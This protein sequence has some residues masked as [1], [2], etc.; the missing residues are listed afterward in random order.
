MRSALLF[1]YFAAKLALFFIVFSLILGSV[2]FLSRVFSEI[3]FRP[4][5][6]CTFVN[7]RGLKSDEQEKYCDQINNIVLAFTITASGIVSIFWI[8][9]QII[10]KR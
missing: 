3:V 4:T 7:S 1:V 6:V 10:N 5:T 9:K 2:I 8:N